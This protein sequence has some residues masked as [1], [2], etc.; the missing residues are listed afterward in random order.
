[1]SEIATLETAK[2]IFFLICG[3]MIGGGLGWLWSLGAQAVANQSSQEA[4]GLRQALHNAVRW[5]H[6]WQ[7]TAL[8]LAHTKKE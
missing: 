8:D 1:M 7:Q 6:H 2:A 4:E 5:L 3:L